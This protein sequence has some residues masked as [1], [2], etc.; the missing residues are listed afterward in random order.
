MLLLLQCCL[1]TLVFQLFLPLQ[2]RKGPSAM[3]HVTKC[4]TRQCCTYQLG[5]KLQVKHC[6]HWFVADSRG[7]ISAG[8]R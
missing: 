3:L 7:R 4:L 6:G 5:N 2:S 8:W 1:Q